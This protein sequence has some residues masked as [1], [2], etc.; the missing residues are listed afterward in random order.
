[1]RGMDCTSF[2]RGALGINRLVHLQRFYKLVEECT[3]RLAGPR[4]LSE[5]TGRL[6]WPRRGVY[7][8]FEPGEARGETGTGSRIVRGGTHAL[9]AGSSRG[10]GCVRG[11][12]HGRAEYY[13]SYN[14]LMAKRAPSTW[15]RSVV[16]GLRTA[17]P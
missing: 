2:R 12:Q 16:S 11:C 1:M 4:R 3:S 13:E 6:E 7:F 15:V 14:K 5:C 17:R 10:G 9:K 8:F